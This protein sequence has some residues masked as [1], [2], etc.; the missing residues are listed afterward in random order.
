M[1]GVIRSVRVVLLSLCL[2]LIFFQDV[3]T[4]AEQRIG[5]NDGNKAEETRRKIIMMRN[6][7][8][9]SDDRFRFRFVRRKYADIPALFLHPH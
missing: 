7:Y 6:E 4:V 1:S 2:Y 9:R 5:R 8:L 3:R